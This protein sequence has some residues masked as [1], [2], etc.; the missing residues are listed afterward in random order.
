MGMGDDGGA[1]LLLEVDESREAERLRAEA[2][3]T[4]KDWPRTAQSL[5]KIIRM[6]EIPKNQP[7]QPGQALDILNY[8][9]AL[10]LSGNDRGLAQ[11]RENYGDAM[12]AT[13]LKDAF[14]LIAT[15]E[16]FGLISFESIPSKV[17]VAENFQTFLAEYKERLEAEALSQIN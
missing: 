13:D 6:D 16:Q 11:V 10:T 15:P 7:L 9:I 8:T 5:R 1:I 12:R 3:W 17:R 2:F 4:A 14:I